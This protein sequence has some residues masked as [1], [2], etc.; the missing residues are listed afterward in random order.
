[1]DCFISER[2]VLY[3]VHVHVFVFLYTIDL[4][5]KHISKQNK[6]MVQMRLFIRHCK[7]K[8]EIAAVGQ[9]KNTTEQ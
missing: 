9:A 4:K 7:I 6:I 1:M 8:Y 3:S 2:C 5:F